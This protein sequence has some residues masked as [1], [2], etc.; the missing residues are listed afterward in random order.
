MKHITF[1]FD[2]ISPYAYLAFEHLP[3]ALMGNS[4]SMTYQPI[5]FAGALNH[6]GQLGP[7]EIPPKRDWTYRQILWLARE[8]S[9]PLQ[10]PAAHPFNP[11]ALQ[12][13]AVAVSKLGMPNRITVERL[14][15]HVWRNG[16]AADD[17]GRLQALIDE[18]SPA[19]DP[20]S[21]EVKAKLKSNTDEAIAKGVFGVPTFE[22]DGKLFFGLDALPMLAAYLKGDAWFNDVN[23][24]IAANIPVAVSRKPDTLTG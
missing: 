10:F 11:L 24:N 9:I 7:A 18:L 3:A 1:Y 15:H 6:H 17:G 23:W 16:L 14:F 19:Q 13:F 20:N 4:Y 12:R 2:V 5:L 8:L 21:P 22:V